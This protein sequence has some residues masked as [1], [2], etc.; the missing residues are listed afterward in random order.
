MK[1]RYLALGDAMS[2]EAYTQVQGASAPK[3]LAAK[4]GF[5]LIDLTCDGCTIGQAH[6][7][8]SQQL[9]SV[10]LVTVTVGAVDLFTGIDLN[11]ILADYT[12]LVSLARQI[13]PRVILNTI[14]APSTENGAF[15]QSVI[16]FSAASQFNQHVL[17]WSAEGGVLI[18]DLNA[19]FSPNYGEYMATAFAPYAIGAAAIASLWQSLL[20]GLSL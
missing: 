16:P 8:L 14:V 7:L 2:I 6:Q 1:K 18:A 20:S 19:F 5:E 15:I 9:G 11:R 17:S 3:M 4:L 10:D 13:S 12:Q